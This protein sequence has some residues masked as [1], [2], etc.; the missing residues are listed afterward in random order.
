MRKILLIVS[1]MLVPIMS[2]KLFMA[3]SAILLIIS[4]FGISAA[5]GLPDETGV[6][7]PQISYEHNGELDYLVTLIPSYLFGPVP[8]PPPPPPPTPTPPPPLSNLKYPYDTLK[9]FKFSFNYGFTP[10]QPVKKI[11][12]EVW[13]TA[14][15]VNAEGKW[16]TLTLYPKSTAIGDFTA[17]F[18][19]TISDEISGG[20]ITVNIY[21]S[22]IV[23]TDNGIIFESFIQPVYIH[24]QKPVWEV[25]R[26]SLSF[27]ETGYL[28]VLSYQ[29]KGKVE[30]SVVMKADSPLGEVTIKA[31]PVPPPSPTPTPTPTPEPPSKTI[32]PGQTIFI[33]LVGKMDASFKY[34][35]RADRPVRDLNEEVTINAILENPKVW[36][37]SFV[38]VPP[39]KKSGGFSISFPIDI[40]EF[41]KT[42]EAIRNETGVSAESYNLTI[43]ADVHTV[44][45]TDYGPI[46]EVFSSTWSTKLEKGTIEWAEKM[47]QSK[48]GSIETT[49][50]VPNSSRYLG[51][52]VAGVRNL[53]I[54]FAVIFL[55]LLVVSLM[56]FTRAKPVEVPVLEKQGLRF[57]KKYGERMAEATAQAPA[58]ETI[59][60]LGSMEDLVKIADELG[61]PIIHQAPTGSQQIHAYYVIDGRT[62][63][64]YMLTGGSKEKKAKPEE[65]KSSSTGSKT[66]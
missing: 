27:S 9:R 35:F 12:E 60:T 45:R 13:A 29:Q 37:K 30:L 53:S 25:E 42:L 47:A 4:I 15:G 59:I 66:D 5:F 48:A 19:L 56:L 17:D 43:R 8:Q 57:R 50:L 34:S 63:Y 33:K 28:G 31:P 38:L 20:D 51:Q 3:I 10:E 54:A 7:V 18:D 14:T 23:E 22:S 52:S 32:R 49:G 41:S 6:Q 55:A 21:V 44:G 58:G 64:Q 61:K 36:S 1:P 65:P 11:T 26:N 24:E 46:D 62:R 2:S 16:T 39:T 40:N